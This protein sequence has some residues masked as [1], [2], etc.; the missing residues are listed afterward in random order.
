M[1]KIV[2]IVPL[3]P[4]DVESVCAH[5]AHDLVRVRGPGHAEQLKVQ[6]EGADVYTHIRD[7]RLS[8]FVSKTNV[9]TV[10][11]PLYKV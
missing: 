5:A 4:V 8:F 11:D 2:E 7:A 6:A 3:Y 10:S 9:I 1:P